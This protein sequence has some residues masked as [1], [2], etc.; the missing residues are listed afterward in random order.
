MSSQSS[1][2]DSPI[3]PSGDDWHDAPPPNAFV[4]HLGTIRRRWN[5]NGWTY[6]LLVEERHRNGA[7]VM[8]GGAMSALIDEVI[9][10]V[11][12]DE[13][14]RQHVTVQFSMTFLRPVHVGD[15]LELACEIVKVTRSMSFVESRLLV[16]GDAAATASL[17]LKAV[18]QHGS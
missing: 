4:E 1:P 6:G 2:H 12:R 11:A 18:R 5:G 7:G 9:G 8:H 3:S 14:G 16:A 17:V 15:F 10:T 13:V